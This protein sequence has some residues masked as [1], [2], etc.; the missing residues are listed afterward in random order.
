VICQGT[1]VGGWTLYLQDGKLHYAHNWVRR[2]IFRVSSI[3][4]V[5]AGQR[6]LRFEFEPT[7]PPDM[8]NGKGALAAPSCTWTATW[9]ARPT[10]PTPP[11][12]CSTPATS[13]EAPAG[14]PCGPRLHSTLRLHRQAQQGHH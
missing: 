9:W 6:E 7:G 2:Q 10:C 1:V 4:A 14:L 11:C 3:E 5:P 12:S 8:A 13:P